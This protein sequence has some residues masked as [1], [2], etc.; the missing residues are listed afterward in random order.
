LLTQIEQQRLAGTADAALSPLPKLQDNPRFAQAARYAAGEPLPEEAQLSGAADRATE[1]ASR[2]TD[3]NDEIGNLE[4]AV[5][6]AQSTGDL[7]AA[8]PELD[9]A[10]ATTARAEAS[11]RGYAQA[12][13]CLFKAGA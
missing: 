2:V 12:A 4:N 11:R 5:R 3:I 9:A 10:N 8:I 7:P 6:L 1:N 13:M